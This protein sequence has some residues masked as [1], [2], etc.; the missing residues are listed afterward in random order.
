MQSM[1]LNI[2]TDCGNAPKKELI[3]DLTI[4]FV[5]YDLEKAMEYMDENVVWTLVGDKPIK[6]KGPF[7]AALK[8]M[9]GNKAA[10]LTIYSILTHGKEAAVNGEMTMED[11][12]VFGFADFYEFTS[13]GSSK[14]KNIRSYVIHKK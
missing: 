2:Q 12:S 9:M 10:E 7:A 13:A 4:Y 11:G 1:K 6:G 14:V 5:S 8:E 3:R